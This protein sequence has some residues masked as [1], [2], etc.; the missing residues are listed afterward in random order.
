MEH[1]SKAP[2]THTCGVYAFVVHEIG[3]CPRC[4][5]AIRGDAAGLDSRDGISERV[6]TGRL[7]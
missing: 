5:Q 7:H 2:V 4:R 1:Y 3:E 6:F